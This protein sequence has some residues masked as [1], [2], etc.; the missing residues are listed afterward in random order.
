MTRLIPIDIQKFLGKVDCKTTSEKSTFLIVL[1]I[2]LVIV[3]TACDKTTG[4]LVCSISLSA[5]EAVD[6]ELQK[7][8]G[9][10]FASERFSDI[11]FQFQPQRVPMCGSSYNCVCSMVT[12]NLFNRF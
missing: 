2:G 3:A 1:L 12:F 11:P 8:C 9:F 4:V 7:L 6:K 5:S 10:G